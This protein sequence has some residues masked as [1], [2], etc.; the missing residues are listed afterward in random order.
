MK[1]GCNAVVLEHIQIVDLANI[2]HEYAAVKRHGRVNYIGIDISG[3]RY[4]TYYYVLGMGLVINCM[5]LK[6]NEYCRTWNG[7]VSY[8]GP[9]IL[10]ADVFHPHSQFKG[11]NWLALN[12]N[13]HLHMALDEFAK[14]MYQILLAE[15]TGSHLHPDPRVNEF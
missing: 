12:Y 4:N 14:T 1:C 5:D 10:C 6:K 7:N 15:E 8:T 2:V 9:D 3:F 13:S 11:L